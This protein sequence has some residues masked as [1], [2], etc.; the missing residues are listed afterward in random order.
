MTSE[1]TPPAMSR[2]HSSSDAEWIL[3][4]IIKEFAQSLQPEERASFYA[5]LA[6]LVTM[7]SSDEEQIGENHESEFDAHRWIQ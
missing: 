7:C 3:E 4:M 6:E 5:R 1:A 2:V